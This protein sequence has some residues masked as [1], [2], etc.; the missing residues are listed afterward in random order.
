MSDEL[1]H[2]RAEQWLYRNRKALAGTQQELVHF[3]AKLRALS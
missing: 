2:F 1:R 3:V